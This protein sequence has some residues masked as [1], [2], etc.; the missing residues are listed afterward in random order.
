[1]D[2]GEQLGAGGEQGVMVGQDQAAFA[3]DGADRRVDL[4]LDAGARSGVEVP[5]HV[6]GDGRDGG[7]QDLR[8]RTV[9]VALAPD[10]FEHRLEVPA[11]PRQ[12]RVVAVDAHVVGPQ[13]QQDPFRLG[14]LDDARAL[15]EAEVFGGV[16]ALDA[17][18]DHL[19]AQAVALEHLL[20]QARIDIGGDAVAG[21][22]D[23]RPAGQRRH[24]RLAAAGEREEVQ[25]QEDQRAQKRLHR[26]FGSGAQSGRRSSAPSGESRSGVP[27]CAG[28]TASDQRLRF[29]P[30]VVS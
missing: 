5:A 22:Q 16:V 25:D 18:V 9:A 12:G 4:G 30:V 10:A 11:E 7:Q 6:V 14:A 21:A 20:Q 26:A 15:Q 24:G 1:M 13:L 27:P 3:G 2:V 17:G 19:H 28:I 29:E 23:H 8:R